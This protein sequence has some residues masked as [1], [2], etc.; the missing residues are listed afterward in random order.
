MARALRWSSGS[1]SISAREKFVESDTGMCV[2][3]SPS[4]LSG[5]GLLIARLG[6]FAL[7]MRDS[8]MARFAGNE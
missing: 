2:V 1:A 7:G 3:G 4:L 5:D 6:E 8:A